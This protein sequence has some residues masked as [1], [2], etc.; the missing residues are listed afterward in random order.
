MILKTK[1]VPFIGIDG[2]D[3]VTLKR[4]DL[5]GDEYNRGRAHGA[6]LA[7]EI[8][9]F[10]KIRLPIYYADMIL[11]L[12]VSML[13]KA[14]QLKIKALGL[15]APAIFEEALKYVYG[16]E[17]K[18]IPSNLIQEM[19]GIGDG[20]CLTL[21]SLRKTC[22]PIEWATQIKYVNMLPELIRMVI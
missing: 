9:E 22:D 17:E 5:V 20:I 19:D 16:L 8:E 13:P 3:T 10:V 12:D 15:K 18:Y 21:A 2:P 6:L 14:L 7:L 11:K 4:L 1:K